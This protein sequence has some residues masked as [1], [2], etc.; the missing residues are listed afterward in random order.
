VTRVL[1]PARV[2]PQKRGSPRKQ[3]STR[4]RTYYVKHGLQALQRLAKDETRWLRSLGAVGMA[5]REWRTALVHDLGGESAI[6]AQQRAIVEMASKTYLILSSIDRWMLA[7]PS[8]INKRRRALFHIVVQRQ[9]LADS[10]ARHLQALGL[11][12]R[13]A[14]APSLGAYVQEKYGASESPQSP[15]KGPRE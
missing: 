13:P 9:A 14:K 2:S 4:P 7:Q 3:A 10:L 8:L 1:G 15:E 12:R 5:L 6:S 11:E